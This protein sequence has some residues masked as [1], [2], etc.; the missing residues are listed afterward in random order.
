MKK[1][2]THAAALVLLIIFMGC[3]KHIDYLAKRD[4]LN[5]DNA[6][7]KINYMSLYALNPSVQLSLNGERVSGLILGRTPFPGGGYNTNGS[8][9]ADYLSVMPG[10]N[11]LKISIPKKSTNVDSVVLFT[12]TLSVEGTKAYTAHVADTLTNTKVKLVEDSMGVAPVNLSK[13][14]FLN[15]M[16]NVPSIDLYYGTTK[17][18]SAIPYLGYSPYFYVDVPVTALAWTIREAGTLPTSTA[19]ATYTS[20][21]V[22]IS[23][24]VYSIFAVGY[25]GSAAA[26][27]KPYV[28]FNLTN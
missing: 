7:L 25:K 24:R 13:Y 10:T 1:T 19:L 17:V 20:A 15:L 12:T 14:R 4:F 23:T 6:R 28:S 26:N 9:Y 21:N 16:P 22:H 3:E 27:T 18:A 2:I 11:T 8:N 5:D